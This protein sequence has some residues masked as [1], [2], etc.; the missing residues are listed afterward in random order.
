[1]V[2]DW[3]A[4][5]NDS[6]GQGTWLVGSDIQPGRYRTFVE[7]DSALDSCYWARLSGLT[8]SFDD[9]IANDNAMGS[10]YVD[11]LSTDVAF[12]SG[13]GPWSKVE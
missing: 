12:E 11:I 1:M 4:P 9:L 10:V 2:V 13:C 3:P 5:A 8:G 6:F 7:G